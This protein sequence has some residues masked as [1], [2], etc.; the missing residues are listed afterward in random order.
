MQAI[1]EIIREFYIINHF[2]KQII[3]N[4]AYPYHPHMAKFFSCFHF[5][6]WAS[7]YTTVIIMDASRATNLMPYFANDIQGLFGYHLFC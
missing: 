7:L 3:L 6:A 1:W 5:K 2:A 4:P